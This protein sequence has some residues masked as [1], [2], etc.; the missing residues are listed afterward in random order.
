[1]AI[2]YTKV[3]AT[4]ERLVYAV[5]GTDAAA[6][7]R[8]NAQLIADCVAG[9]L[10]SLLQTFTLSNASQAQ[11]SS[12]VRIGLVPAADVHAAAPN[13]GANPQPQG[14]P[15]GPVDFAVF[16]NIAPGMMESAYSAF[17]E[18]QYLHSIIR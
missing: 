11:F 9:P 5:E 16:Q 18:I 2:T 8:T 1:M 15:S 3:S 4:P 12:L 10:K 17:L 13:W 7:I 6:V 14:G